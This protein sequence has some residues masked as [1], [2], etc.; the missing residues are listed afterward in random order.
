MNPTTDTA[1]ETRPYRRAASTAVLDDDEWYYE[2][3]RGWVPPASDVDRRRGLRHHRG[4][5]LRAAAVAL[6]GQRELRA[7]HLRAGRVPSP[8]P[9]HRSGRRPEHRVPALRRRRGRRRALRARAG[10]G[11]VRRRR[12]GDLS[13]LVRGSRRGAGVHRDAGRWRSRTC[14]CVRG[15]RLGADDITLE[16]LA[17]E[18]VGAR[19]R[20]TPRQPPRLLPAH[21]RR[22]AP[23]A[24]DRGVRTAPPSRAQDRPR[25]DRPHDRLLAV[26][27]V[28]GVPRDHRA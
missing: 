23:P 9:R 25:R 15:Q 19:G 14:D 26:P 24:G 12:P 8:G 6:R 3:E 11:H 1:T 18:L 22:V 4:E 7:R 5:R 21:D 10:R 17:L 28:A 20:T 2:D 13:G 27:P 16:T